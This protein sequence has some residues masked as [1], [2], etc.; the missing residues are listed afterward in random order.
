MKIPPHE[1]SATV[2][3]F[4]DFIGEPES[5][6]YPYAFWLSRIGK[7]TYGDAIGMIK[8]LET[9]PIIYSKAGTIINKLKKFNKTNVRSNAD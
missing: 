1:K 4:L 5:K 8:E 3:L 2:N 9:L 6:K 7:C